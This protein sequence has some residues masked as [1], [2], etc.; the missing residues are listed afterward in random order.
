MLLQ[1]PYEQYHSIALSVVMGQMKTVKLLGSEFNTYT[2]AFLILVS[3]VTL[4]RMMK[5]PNNKGKSEQGLL[6]SNE[7]VQCKKLVI[8]TVMRRERLEK[9]YSYYESVHSSMQ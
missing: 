2:P 8:N 1:L 5:S 3:I 9:N 6:E 4:L 7:D